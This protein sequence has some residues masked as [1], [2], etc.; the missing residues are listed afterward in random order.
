LIHTWSGKFAAEKCGVRP[1]I[2]TSLIDA[3]PEAFK[4]LDEF[5]KD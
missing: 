4:A 3:F 2:A 5:L 1:M